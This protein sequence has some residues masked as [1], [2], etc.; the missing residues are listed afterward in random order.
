MADSKLG[1]LDR[2]IKKID[3]VYTKIGGR[4]ENGKKYLKFRI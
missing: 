2:L 4:N 3:F 1:E